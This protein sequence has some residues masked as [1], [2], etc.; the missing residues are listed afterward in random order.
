MEN[1]QQLGWTHGMIDCG[2]RVEAGIYSGAQ[3]ENKMAVSVSFLPSRI[4]H[5]GQI[6]YRVKPA[7]RWM[8]ACSWRPPS[9]T[10]RMIKQPPRKSGFFH[11]RLNNNGF[12]S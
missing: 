9:R 7:F 12:A 6:A 8:K 10:K 5:A 2:K 3:L 1:A 4:A 11:N